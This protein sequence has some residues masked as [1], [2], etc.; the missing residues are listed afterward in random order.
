MP[1]QALY[2]MVFVR[3]WHVCVHDR[4]LDLSRNNMS[5]VA[6][7]AFSGLSNLRSV[8]DCG[9]IGPVAFVRP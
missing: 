9:L 3:G 7:G 5:S 8:R 4:R 6:S 1:W 2:A